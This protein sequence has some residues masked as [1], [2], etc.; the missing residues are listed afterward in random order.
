ML[1]ILL[2]PAVCGKPMSSPPAPAEDCEISAKELDAAGCHGVIR[3]WFRDLDSN[4]DTQLQR[5]MSYQLDDPGSA[6]RSL[7]EESNG[8]RSARGR[9]GGRQRI[10]LRWQVLCVGRLFLLN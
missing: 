6:V 7:A 8:A 4:Q 1:S 9:G 5:L 3:E 2:E 10:W